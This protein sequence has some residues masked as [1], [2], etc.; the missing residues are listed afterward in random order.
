MK[1]TT[2]TALWRSKMSC[3]DLAMS[4]TMLVERCAAGQPEPG[5]VRSMDT[6][7]VLPGVVEAEP[8]ETGTTGLHLCQI[9]TAEPNGGQT[10]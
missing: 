5:K 10:E 7:I 1:K 6:H 4:M 9:C 3:L 2:R 8:V